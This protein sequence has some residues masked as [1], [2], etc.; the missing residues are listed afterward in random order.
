[1]TDMITVLLADDHPTM[2]AGIRAILERAPEVRVIAEAE[3]GSTARRLATG[4]RPDVLLLD[5]RMPGE[6]PLK[7]VAGVK[8]ASP[9]TAVVILTAY[10]T[11]AYLAAM[12]D[13]G[14][15]GF[16]VKDEAPEELVA[17]VRRA[18]QGEVLFS[19]GQKA[20]AR[21][22]QRQVGER[23]GSLTGRERQVLA[24]I[25]EGKTDREIA[26]VLQVTNK[27]VG[28]H[29]SHILEKLQLCS[30][31][32]AALWFEREIAQISLWPLESNWGS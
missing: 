31:T 4:C 6:S 24:L 25:A 17:A 30:R 9:D 12:L 27:T 28:H 7:T 10:D 1:M 16:V 19:R 20:R 8:A 3:D 2:R 14:A 11:G 26:Q 22:W 15:A 23:W 21:R 18:A 13:A 29:V 32:E 5:L